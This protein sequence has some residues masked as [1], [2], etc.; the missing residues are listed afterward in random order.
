MRCPPGAWDR[1]PRGPDCSRQGIMDTAGSAAASG[2]FGPLGDRINGALGRCR[3]RANRSGAT[4]CAADT[5]GVSLAYPALFE[6]GSNRASAFVK[7]LRRR[8]NTR[9][10]PVVAL[11]LL[12]FPLE[13]VTK[14]FARKAEGRPGPP[15]TKQ[16][17]SLTGGGCPHACSI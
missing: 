1:T 4:R 13:G 5:G 10:S 15:L 3:S 16:I 11:L 14:R 2:R 12:P 6:R 9:R 7:T 8:H 17:A